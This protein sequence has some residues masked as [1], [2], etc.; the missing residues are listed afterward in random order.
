MLIRT[1][2]PCT[3]IQWNRFVKG[4]TKEALQ[5]SCPLEVT[6]CC[7]GY[8]QQTVLWNAFSMH[9]FFG[10]HISEICHS[11]M[12]L[13]LRHK[14]LITN[15]SLCPNSPLLQRE[16]VLLASFVTPNKHLLTVRPVIF[17]S[18]RRMMEKFSYCNAVWYHWH[19]S[20]AQQVRAPRAAYIPRRT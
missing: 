15:V 2:I 1:V 9:W 18:K 17:F 6:P 19:I 20:A 10:D 3:S 5:L 12:L 11:Q 8:L 16:K 13:E 7:V 4:F 14:P